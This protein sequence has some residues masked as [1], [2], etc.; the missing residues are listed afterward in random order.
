MSILL[1]IVLL[2]LFFSGAG[3]FIK[4]P[5]NMGN[6]VFLLN[7]SLLILPAIIHEHFNPDFLRYG[8]SL[9][10]LSTSEPPYAEAKLWIIIL[11]VFWMLGTILGQKVVPRRRYKAPE[12]CLIRRKLSPLMCIFL[13]LIP[14]LIFLNLSRN[15]ELSLSEMLLPSRAE[16]GSQKV[17]AYLELLMLGIPTVV[18]CLILSIRERLDRLSLL[19][20]IFAVLL[21][22]STAQRRSMILIMGTLAIC[23]F[24]SVLDSRDLKGRLGR[25]LSRLNVRLIWVLVLL[26]PLGPLFWYARSYATQLVRG[27]GQDAINPFALRGFG[28][29]IFGSAASGFSMVVLV[30][31]MMRETSES[32]FYSILFITTVPI[33]RSLWPAKPLAPDWII[34]SYYGLD[35]SPSIFI[36]PELILN[37]YLLA[38]I[39]AF[40]MALF[41]S[42]LSYFLLSRVARVSGGAGG[43]IALWRIQ[44]AVLFPQAAMIFKN[45]FAAFFINAFLWAALVFIVYHLASKRVYFRKFKSSVV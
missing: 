32:L 40:F 28:E 4:Y 7:S 16:R 5:T 23:Y 37:F 45:G 25:I 6:L 22:I 3:L 27:G 17:S 43:D 9:L 11:T 35:F 29:L 39:A 36:F 38:P 19:F 14:L 42:M 24:L 10:E 20:A 8:M 18:A 30:T 13:A 12:E 44:Y 15:L 26:A 33:P 21:A 31:D 2:G 41:I 34:E 1:D